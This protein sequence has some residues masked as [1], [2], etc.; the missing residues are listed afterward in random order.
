MIDA[1]RINSTITTLLSEG[2]ALTQY[3]LTIKKVGGV[4]NVASSALYSLICLLLNREA[5]G[6]IN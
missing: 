1:L 3:S 2:C 5:A 6:N 4:R